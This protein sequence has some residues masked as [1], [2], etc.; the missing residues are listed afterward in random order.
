LDDKPAIVLVVLFS[1]I[2]VPLVHFTAGEVPPDVYEI[3]K[4]EVDPPPLVQFK[5]TLS[6]AFIVTEGEIGSGGAVCKVVSVISTPTDKSGVGL[7]LTAQSL[8][9]YTVAGLNP[10]TV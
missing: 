9:E 10:V 4:E 5:V 3:I 2:G 1:L 7:S 8:K 6:N